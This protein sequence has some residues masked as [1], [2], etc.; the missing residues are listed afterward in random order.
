MLNIKLRFRLMLKLR[1]RLK[2]GLKLRF[3]L[4]LRPKLR[5][6]LRL[7]LKLKLK[8]RLKLRLRLRLK[9]RHLKLM[10]LLLVH[11]YR[12]IHMMLGRAFERMGGCFLYIQ[13]D[14][15]TNCWG[16]Q[17]QLMEAASYAF[18]SIDSHAVG[19]RI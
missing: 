3:R 1:P 9:L 6:R 10:E 12:L 13:I 7:R 4:R 11:S 14:G 2:L 16:A 17:L 18:R 8:L 15:F 5:L 19:A